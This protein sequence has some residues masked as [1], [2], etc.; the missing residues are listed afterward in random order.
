MECLGVPWLIPSYFE[1][2]L[3]YAY[4]GPELHNQIARIQLTVR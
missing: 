4:K 3:K 2:L 1:E